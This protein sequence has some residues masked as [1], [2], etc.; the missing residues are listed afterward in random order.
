MNRK[1]VEERGAG[2]REDARQDPEQ[3][4][5]EIDETRAN[6][7][8]TLRALEHKLSPEALIDRMLEQLRQ[9]GGELAGNLGHTVKQ[10][11][12][13]MLLTSVGIAWMMADSRRHEATSKPGGEHGAARTR[14]GFD[15]LLREQPL[16]LGAIGIAAGAVV[17]A[18][19]PRSEEEDGILGPAS[20]EGVDRLGRP[21]G[22]R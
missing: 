3:L 21:S 13:A 4:A 16:L 7:R 1:K 6:V 19:L 2:R 18:A 20:D 5:Q 10:N 11:P 9:H 15:H 8:A 17:G 12:I 14:H 22:C